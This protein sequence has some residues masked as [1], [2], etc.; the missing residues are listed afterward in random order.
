LVSEALKAKLASGEAEKLA[1]ELVIMGTG[2]A[3]PSDRIA[4]IS[5]ITDRVEGKAT[6]RIDTR[7]LF[8]VMAP[9]QANLAWADDE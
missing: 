5:E 9:E 7:G 2:A 1:N 8:V 6:Q 3:R 4:A